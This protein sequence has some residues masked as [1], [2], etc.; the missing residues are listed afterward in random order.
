M[1]AENHYLIPEYRKREYAIQGKYLLVVTDLEGPESII[2]D[3][4][5]ENIHSLKETLDKQ[6]GD[7]KKI[8]QQN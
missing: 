2:Q 3:P 8:Q 6:L 5:I 1:I 7:I 4:I